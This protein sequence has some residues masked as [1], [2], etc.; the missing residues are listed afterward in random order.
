MINPKAAHQLVEVFKS[1]LKPR[2][3]IEQEM[4]AV[5]PLPVLQIRSERGATKWLNITPQQFY[6]IEEI[7]LRE[8]DC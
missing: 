3:Y 5:A 2:T 7:L 1:Q 6:D 8:L 4:Y